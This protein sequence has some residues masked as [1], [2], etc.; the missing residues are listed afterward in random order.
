MNKLKCFIIAFIILCLFSTT[1]SQ[2]R[3]SVNEFPIKSSIRLNLFGMNFDYEHYF[4]KNA[5]LYV[6]AGPNL[7]VAAGQFGA[8]GK[9]LFECRYYPWLEKRYLKGR[10]LKSFT[11]LYIAEHTMYQI[12][13]KAGTDFYLST[14]PISA[15]VGYQQIFLKYFY[16]NLQF[17]Y[18][19]HY[20][21]ELNYFKP[22]IVLGVQ[23]GFLI[24]T[25]NYKY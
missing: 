6:G 2:D 20:L 4:A 9:L 18:G 12:K 19:I 11:G 8:S 5:T 15:I 25:R 14:T 16:T 22:D 21:R 3:N 1:H 10:H 17:G 23:L 13:K 24:K 7:G